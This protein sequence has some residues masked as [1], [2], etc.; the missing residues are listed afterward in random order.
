M[1]CGCA[2]RAC[3]S[4]RR[5]EMRCEQEKCTGTLVSRTLDQFDA[6]AL[7]GFP[8]IVVG[9][10][11]ERRCSVC[12]FIAG[13]SV[14][15]E[16]GL[17]KAA[18]LVRVQMPMRLTPQEVR[19]LRRAAGFRSNELADI[20]NVHPSTVSHW[21]GRGPMHPAQETV[22]RVTVAKELVSKNMAPAV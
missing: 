15:D 14:P 9:A 1:R 18:A 12:D 2:C 4:S 20:L 13:V 22:F 10:A 7:I 16:E 8:V 3:V 6:S 17:E 21:E 19:F 11:E 5:I